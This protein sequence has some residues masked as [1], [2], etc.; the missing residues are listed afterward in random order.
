MAE[1]GKKPDYSQKLNTL[2]KQELV[3]KVMQWMIEGNSFTKITELIHEEAPVPLHP[4]FCKNLLAAA[5]QQLE[6]ESGQSASAVIG[7]HVSLYEEIF[8]YFDSVDCAPG[9]NMAMKQKE[10]LLQLHKEENTL[11]INNKR[12]TT[13][14]RKEPEYNKTKL[15]EEENMRMEYLL[16]KASS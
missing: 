3:S 5:R 9:V 14:I 6:E 15:T 10:K 12:K 1:K 13:I 8:N 4:Y 16:K 11:V 7:V 2:Q